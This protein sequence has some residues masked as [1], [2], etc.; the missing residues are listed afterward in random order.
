MPANHNTTIYNIMSKVTALYHIV[1]CTKRREMTIPLTHTD[2]LYR[3]IWKEIQLLNCRLLRIGGI[4]N[5]IHLLIDLN[6]SVALSSLVRNIKGHSS[7]WMSHD[8]RYSSFAGWAGE[9]YATTIAYDQIHNVI[10]YIKGQR[11]HHLGDVLDDEFA[12]LYGAAGLR[13]DDRDLR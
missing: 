9:Y 6:P 5:H 11:Q 13:Y 10:E 8:T 7:S 1:F 12:R 2:D 4:Q 3:F